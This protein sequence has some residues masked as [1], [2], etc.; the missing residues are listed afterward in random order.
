MKKDAPVYKNIVELGDGAKLF[1]SG[2]RPPQNEKTAIAV[3][4]ADV[5]LAPGSKPIDAGQRLPGFNDDLAGSGP[6]LDAY[7]LGV[8]PPHYGPRD[9]K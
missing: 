6:D 2:V 3:K 5:Q 1:A 4:D 9:E 8:K 7:E